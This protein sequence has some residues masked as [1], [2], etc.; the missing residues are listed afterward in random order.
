MILQFEL[1]CSAA[2]TDGRPVWG[3]REG[4]QSA[5]EQQEKIGYKEFCVRV[6]ITTKMLF[7]LATKF[8]VHPFSHT[9]IH[10]HTLATDK[11][12]SAKKCEGSL[13]VLRASDGG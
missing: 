5:V 6:A 10:T 7:G 8:S 9:S 13:V 11:T 1:R 2:F 12:E 3:A 4:G